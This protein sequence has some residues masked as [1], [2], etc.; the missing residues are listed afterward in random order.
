MIQ[1][2]FRL[3]SAKMDLEKRKFKFWDE[4]NKEFYDYNATLIQKVFR[5]YY[6]RKYTH[7]F[8]AR[9]KYLQEIKKKVFWNCVKSNCTIYPLKKL[10]WDKDILYLV[11]VLNSVSCNILFPFEFAHTR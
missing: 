9:K 1:Q 8:F 11:F 10:V 5:G 3:Y 6:A 4:K 7:D 2:R